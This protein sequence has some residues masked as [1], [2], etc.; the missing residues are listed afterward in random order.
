MGA[1]LS[2]LNQSFPPKSTFDVRDIPDLTGK[3]VIV[4][5]ANTG[6]G[7]ETVK[8]LLQHNAKVYLAARDQVK[9]ETAIQEL[10]FSTGNEAIFLKLDLG[11]LKAIKAAAEEF[12]S[13]ETRLDV[14]VNNAGVMF[15][16]I[17]DLTADGYDLQFGTNVLGHH[18]FTKLLLPTL[19]S[20]AKTSSDGKARVVTVSSSAHMVGSLEFG[21]FQDT[22]ARKNIT[23]YMLYAQSKYG[24][25]VF[26]L[27]LDRRCKSEGIVSISLN[28]GNIQS[29]LQRNMGS[30]S[31]SLLGTM[32]YDT[33]HG[34]LT[35]LY[36][37]TSP[38]AAELG[39]Q[40]LLPWARIGLSRKD[41]HDPKL[42]QVLWEWCEEQVKDV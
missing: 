39:G 36:A 3:V 42:G 16:P 32:L 11:N 18:Y 28:P 9:G 24:N 27:E 37:A 13:K 1:F 23:T 33:A 31:R 38:A 41:A 20:T 21:T 14:L 15:S 2:L 7:K 40:Y 22:P 26:A 34:A 35:Q 30:I 25:V 10:K 29:D 5:G 17:E 12:L 6:I 4:T 8:A 19:I